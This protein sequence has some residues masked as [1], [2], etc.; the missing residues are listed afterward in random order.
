MYRND[1][2]VGF[3]GNGTVLWRCIGIC[4][5]LNI[6]TK[7]YK[8][9]DNINCDVLFVFRYKKIIPKQIIDSIP[10]GAVMTHY[11]KLPEY[12][13]Y[14][15]INQAIRKGEC[16]VGVTMFYGDDGVDT[17][18]IINQRTIRVG[19][20]DTV[21]E[22]YSKCDTIA[23]E[24]FNEVIIKFITGKV[25]RIKQLMVRKEFKRVD[26]TQVVDLTKPPK[27]I[28]NFIRS[29][30]GLNQEHAYIEDENYK[31]YFDKTTLVKK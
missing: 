8:N 14:Y 27:E 12:R 6:K 22:I 15:P 4:K 10:L 7:H 17:G 1:I 24:M 18:D 9:H 21:K 28:H 11:S 25:D 20:N 5:R 31:L 3:L 23:I 16:V 2:V 30:T 29:L 26:L 19:I 13:G